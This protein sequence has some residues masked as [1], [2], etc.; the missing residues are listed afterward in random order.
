MNASRSFHWTIPVFADWANIFSPTSFI[1]WVRG[2]R[3]A[4]HSSAYSVPSPPFAWRKTEMSGWLPKAIQRSRNFVRPQL[5]TS[6][7]GTRRK[8]KWL[9][10]L[11]RPP[12]DSNTNTS[13]NNHAF[14][15]EIES[16]IGYFIKIWHHLIK[17]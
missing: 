8:H 6:T 11:L 5:K 10:F 15:K 4:A 14:S 16:I 7:K 12:L 1:M 17:P 2:V 3:A 13:I 9:P